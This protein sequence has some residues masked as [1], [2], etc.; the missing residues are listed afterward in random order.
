MTPLAILQDIITL[1]RA[2]HAQVSLMNSNKKDLHDLTTI[3]QQIVTSLQGLATLPSN[4]QFIDSLTAFQ[5]CLTDTQKLI[6][7]ISKMSS[8]MRLAYAQ[9]NKS[10]ISTAKQ[11][12]F[13]FISL[14]NLGLNAQLLIDHAND[15]RNVAQAFRA[16]SPTGQEYYKRG[17]SF[18]KAGDM[19]EARKNYQ[20]SY[21]KDFFKAYTRVGLFALEGQAGVPVDKQKAQTCFEHAARHGHADAMFNLGRMFEK[22]CTTTG[23]QD[24]D[25]ALFWYKKALKVDPEHARYQEKVTALTARA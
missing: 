9:T 13:E 10:N 15:R 23:I 2:I 5:Q 19:V 16:P 4:Q 20:R 12:M 11:R 14:I 17:V 21:Q 1:A 18:E 3:M 25:T 24:N 7:S 22:G 8:A 6:Q